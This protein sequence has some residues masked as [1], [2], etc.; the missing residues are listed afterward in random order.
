ML[1]AATTAR[2]SRVG[3]QPAM[4]RRRPFC[5]QHRQAKITNPLHVDGR[6]SFHLP[7]TIAIPEGTDQGEAPV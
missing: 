2:S 4:V 7:S 5:V 6:W 1:S 3:T